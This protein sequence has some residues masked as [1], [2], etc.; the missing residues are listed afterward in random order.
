MALKLIACAQN[1]IPF[2]IDS[3]DEV[4]VK[5]LTPPMFD[6]ETSKPKSAGM[7]LASFSFLEKV[8]PESFSRDFP[9]PVSIHPSRTGEGGDQE[10]V[11]IFLFASVV[12]FHGSRFQ[13]RRILFLFFQEEEP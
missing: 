12:D 13:H 8:V 7:W 4:L 11:V 10:E 1:D 3:L 6:M 2:D 9:F 5:D